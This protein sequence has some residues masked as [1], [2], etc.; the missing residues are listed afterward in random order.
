M[1]RRLDLIPLPASVE[2]LGG[3][4]LTITPDTSPVCEDA[5]IDDSFEPEGYALSITAEGALL[6]A[7]T[8]QGLAHGRQ[9]WRQLVAQAEREGEGLPNIVIKDEPR[10][11]WRGGHLDVCRHFFPLEAVKRY[12]DWLAGYKFNVFH[13]HLQKIR[14][15]GWK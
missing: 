13:W 3:D 14:G 5:L 6:E 2:W 9:T 4:E 1:A 7:S 15:G 10:F 11:P 8:P 12:I